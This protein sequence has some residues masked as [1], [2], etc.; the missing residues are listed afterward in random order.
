MHT[1]TYPPSGFPLPV[2]VPSLSLLTHT[3]AHTKEQ[4]L[5]HSIIIGLI[6]SEACTGMH[7]R[8]KKKEKKKAYVRRRAASGFYQQSIT[9]RLKP[10]PL[11]GVNLMAHYP[12]CHREKI[13][14][15]EILPDARLPRLSGDE[16]LPVIDVCSHGCVCMYACICAAWLYIGVSPRVRTDGGMLTPWQA[17]LSKLSKQW[18]FKN[19]PDAHTLSH[20]HTHTHTH[21]L[22]FAH[23]W[24]S[25]M[26]SVRT[27]PRVDTV[28]GGDSSCLSAARAQCL[29]RSHAGVCVCACVNVCQ[30]VR[31]HLDAR[32][33][34]CLLW[35]NPRLSVAWQPDRETCTYRKKEKKKDFTV[36]LT[37]PKITK[38]THTHTHT[39]THC[40]KHLAL[41]WNQD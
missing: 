34:T 24:W 27:N 40:T 20:T 33:R 7:C 8:E 22:T 39:H 19:P 13:W 30:C 2:F 28:T 15:K 41:L 3:L 10:P 25:G 11:F 17:E 26:W 38:H 16:H 18:Y 5:P 9:L 31:A 36:S 35:T 1:H 14:G 29:L 6:L 12:T 21:A 4:R 32:V 23:C 37:S